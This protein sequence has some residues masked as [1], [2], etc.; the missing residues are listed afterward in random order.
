MEDVDYVW[1][2]RKRSAD[3]V[4]TGKHIP[5]ELAQTDARGCSI[6]SYRS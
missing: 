2:N 5:A 3:K 4:Y 6:D 1:L